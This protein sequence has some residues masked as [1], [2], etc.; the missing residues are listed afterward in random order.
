M[1]FD[2]PPKPTVKAAEIDAAAAPTFWATPRRKAEDSSQ[3]CRAMAE[4]DRNRAAAMGSDR[5]RFRLERSA[6]AWAARADMLAR[7]ET[8]AGTRRTAEAAATDETLPAPASSGD[9]H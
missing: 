4:D 3:G 6:D 9:S 5:M 8:S 7:L 2:S 1:V